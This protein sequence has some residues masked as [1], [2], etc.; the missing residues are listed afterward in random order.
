MDSLSHLSSLAEKKIYDLHQNSSDNL[1]YIKFL[2]RLFEPVVKLL[3][4]EDQGL[5]FGCGNGP[6]LAKLFQQAGHNMTLYDPYYFPDQDSLQKKYQFILATEV[7]EHFSKPKHEIEKI[8]ALLM[9]NGILAIMTKLAL[10]KESFDK[11][12]YKND[13]THVCFFSVETFNWI[14]KRYSL[15]LTFHGKDVII[16]QK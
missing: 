14:A 9:S 10:N 3:K 2:T 8:L 12:H 15:S 16:L 1:G 7:I 5:D 6:V 4:K 13:P 11:W